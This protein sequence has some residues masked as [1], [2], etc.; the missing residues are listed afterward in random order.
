MKNDMS[1]PS[2]EK[3]IKKIEYSENVIDSIVKTQAQKILDSVRYKQMS[4]L[5]FIVVKNG[6]IPYANKLLPEANKKLEQNEIDI[7]I[8]RDSILV[9]SYAGTESGKVCLLEDIETDIK[10]KIVYVIEDMYDKGKTLDFLYKHLLSKK[11]KIIRFSVFL[12]RNMGNINN[13]Y[14]VNI[15]TYYPKNSYLIG[16]GLDYYGKYRDL[17]Y[18]ASIKDEYKSNSN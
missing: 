6:A 16:F 10:D 7:Q 1:V 18:I 11:P 5:I 8:V 17:P 14:E 4:D 15:G 12:K 9:K 2:L 3:I 13:N